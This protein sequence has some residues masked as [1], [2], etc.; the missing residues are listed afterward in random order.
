VVR[1]SFG[2]FEMLPAEDF[3]ACTYETIIFRYVV[4]S[5]GMRVGGK[6][7]IALPNMGWGEPLPPY[8][9]HGSEYFRNEVRAFCNWKRCNTTY[10]VVSDSKADLFLSS[11]ESYLPLGRYENFR[12]WF[13]W[14]MTASILAEPLQEGDEIVITY[15]DTLFGEEGAFVQPWAE[16]GI[17][18]SAFVD[19]Q[20]CG[21]FHEV[22][23]SPIDCSVTP[24]PIEKCILTAPSIV[25]PGEEFSL[26]AAVTDW[27]EDRLSRVPPGTETT[28]WSCTDGPIDSRR[29]FDE[30]AVDRIDGL[31]TNEGGRC[32][33]EVEL[34]DGSI[35]AAESNP[36]VCRSGGLNLYWGDL[37][38]QSFYHQYDPRLGRGDPILV[39]GELLKYARE[40]THLDFVAITDGGGALSNNAGWQETQQAVVDNYVEGEFVP[41]KGWEIQTQGDGHCNAVYRDAEIEAH[42]PTDAF[43]GGGMEGVLHY[44]GGREDV[45]L[46]PHHTLASLFSNSIPGS[47]DMNWEQ[48]NWNRFDPH[49]NRL[50]EIYSCWGSSESP[51]NDLWDK[52]SPP[53]QSVIEVLSR[54][55][56][57]GFVGGSDS[58]IGFPGRSLPEA[59]KYRCQN[60]KAGYTAVYAPKLTREAIFESLRTRR[61]YATTGA[62]IIVDFSVDGEPLGGRVSGDA[63]TG[64]PTVRASV[65]GTDRIG[66]VD[67]VRDGQVVHSAEPYQERFDMEWTDTS[68]RGA[69]AAYYYVRVRQVDGNAA[70]TSPVWVSAF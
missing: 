5:E 66:R 60:F 16:D 56:Q 9:D 22:P 62:R 28:L 70:W 68:L 45:I 48:F 20:G 69:N 27:G 54:G 30:S 65:M 11:R 58:H 64:Q 49:L 34:S 2:Y 51:D 29:L 31:R 37:H 42:I 15:G 55:Y 25:R 14:W 8:P 41:L 21:D 4:G 63:F 12:W 53:G 18:F 19:P 32:K 40:V 24:G 44:Y 35:V 52:S 36:I 23:G 33:A 13:C 59:E 10:Q 3:R 47:A 50:V 46:I 1:R 67:I 57:L 39:P 26:R 7:K 17:W 61:C 38:A 6:L 43:D